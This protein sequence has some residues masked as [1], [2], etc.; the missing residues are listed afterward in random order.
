MIRRALNG[1]V[2]AFSFLAAILE[3]TVI[4]VATLVLDFALTVSLATQVGVA[5]KDV[6]I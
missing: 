4:A 2:D 6:A 5:V 3:I 1:L